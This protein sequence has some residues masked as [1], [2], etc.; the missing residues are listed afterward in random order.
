M[1]DESGY[2]QA[3]FVTKQTKYAVP[4]SPFS[5]PVKVGSQELN[6]LIN[7]L[8]SSHDVGTSESDSENERNFQFDFLIDGIYLQETLDKHMRLY[9]ISTESVVEIEYL[10]KHPAPRPDNCLLHDDWVSSIAV[11]KK[12]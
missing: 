12:W 5:V 3:R 8:L 1:A 9:N 11:C 6:E 2:V 10:E 7:S 4:E